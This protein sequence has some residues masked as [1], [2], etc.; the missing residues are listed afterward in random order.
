M[1]KNIKLRKKIL[2][3][4]QNS[5]VTLLKGIFWASEKNVRVRVHCI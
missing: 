3:Q 1:E 2:G 5:F 4:Y